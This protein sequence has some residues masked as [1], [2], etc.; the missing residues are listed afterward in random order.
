MK[1]T[2]SSPFWPA[3]IMA[4]GAFLLAA[5]GCTSKRPTHEPLSINGRRIDRVVVFEVPR[6]I[7]VRAALTPQTLAAT[8]QVR[9]ELRFDSLWNQ[10]L[11]G[12]VG[13]TYC[14]QS[15]GNSDLRTGIIFFASDGTPVKSF[16]YGADPAIGM[17]DETPCR[18]GPALYKWVRKQL[19]EQ[20]RNP[21]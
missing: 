6:D 4:C 12:A 10:D 2:K 17:I 9:L 11:N 13:Q 21:F 8:Y 3:V 15:A 14:A 16:Y 5:A 19:P 18:L 20:D 1:R 7:L